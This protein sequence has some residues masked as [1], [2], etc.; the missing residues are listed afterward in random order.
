MEL[1]QVIKK[2]ILTEKT[3][4]LQAKNIYTFEVNWSANKYQIKNAVETIFQVKVEKINTL[5]VDKKYKRVGRF[6]GF[7]NRYKKAMVTLKEGYSINYYPNENSEK[8]NVKKELK[9]QQIKETKVKNKA[10]EALLAEK[11]ANKKASAV[12]NKAQSNNSAA[13]KTVSRNK[14]E[15]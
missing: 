7:L 5:K 2:P 15:A 13:R 12:K 4:L 3:N 9:E 8:E 14:K 10:K 1:T 11:I 6:E